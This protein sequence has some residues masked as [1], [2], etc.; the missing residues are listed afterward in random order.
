[1][2]AFHREQIEAVVRDDGR[3]G[4]AGD[5]AAGGRATVVDVYDW[6]RVLAMRIAMRALLGLDPD[7][8]G[9]GAAIAERF[10]RAL[11]FYGTDCPLRLLRGPGSP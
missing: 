7:D 10:E 1:M 2:P 6:M 4:R 11:R 8:H 3:R 5:R 9:S